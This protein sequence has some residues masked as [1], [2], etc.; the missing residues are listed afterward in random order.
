MTNDH[1]RRL[2]L[3]WSFL[4]AGIF[5]LCAAYVPASWPSRSTFGVFGVV[6][7]GSVALLGRTKIVRDLL[8]RRPSGKVGLIKPLFLGACVLSIFPAMF[9]LAEVFQQEPL[10]SQSQVL[11]NA[12]LA[13]FGPY[14]LVIAYCLLAASGQGAKAKR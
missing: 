11:P 3:A 7:L 10:G 5:V 14:A 9:G 4:L 2:L 12:M 13:V 1:A 6:I 8:R